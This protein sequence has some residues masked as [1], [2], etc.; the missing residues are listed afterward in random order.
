MA[1]FKCKMCGGDL[2]I[3]EGTSIA[4]CEYCGTRQTLPKTVDENLN[5]MFNRA[6]TLRIKSEFDK[7]EKLY[8]K[9][10]QVE[11]TQA[12]AY[13]GLILCR[14]GI[15]YVDDP[16][17]LKKIPTCHRASYDSIVADE[18]FKLALAHA[19]E[20]QRAVYEAEAREIDRIQKEI[21]ALAQKEETYDVFICYKETDANGERTHDSVIA[22]DIYYQ[23]KEQG[24]RVFY[25]AITLEGKLGSA[26]EPIIFAALHSAKVMLAI[27]TR[28]EYFNAVWVKNEWSRFL[29]IIK[30]DR[31]KLLIPCYR[32]MDA[33]ELPEEFA[34]LQAQ[35]MAKIGFINDIVRGIKRVM[36]ND[37]PKKQTVVKETVVTAT[38]PNI[39]P[40]L[41][42]AFMFLEDGDFEK[43]DEFCEQVLNQDPE[44]ARAYLGKLMAELG[45]KKE[46][47]LADCETPFDGNYNY[48]KALRFADQ[49]FESTLVGYIE[50][51]RT[52]IESARL[53][54]LYTEAYNAMENA[55]TEEEY[56]NAEGLF[57]SI[58]G[59]RD[60]DKLAEACREHAETARKDAILAKALVEIDKNTERSYFEAIKLLGSIPGWKSADEWMVTCQQNIEELKAKA[61]AYRL[62]NERLAELSRQRA[63]ERAKRLK[64]IAAIATPVICLI[65]VL[66]LLF[67]FVIIPN[68]KYNDAIALMDDG[69]Y[70]EAVSLFNELDGYK[71]SQEKSTVCMNAIRNT[72]EIE[73]QYN[74][75][76]SLMNAKRYE[77]AIAAF[78]V[79]KEYKDSATKINECRTALMDVK[80]NAAV[81]L[82]E[83][84]Q[85]EDAIVAFEALNGY[86]DSVDK[87]NEC[88]QMIRYREA[89]ELMNAKKYGEALAIF[90]DLGDFRESADKVI[91]CQNAIQDTKYDVAIRLLNAGAV[92][93]AYEA[94]I[95]LNG[96]KDSAE[97]AASI[98]PAYKI[99]KLK[100]A[101]VGTCVFFGSYEQDN[102][103]SNGQEELEW[104]VLDVQDGKALVISK[105]G[106]D[107]IPYHSSNEDITWEDCSLRGWLNNEFL[108]T[109]FSETDRVAI[110]TVTV[111]AS[112]NAQ[113]QTDPGNETQDQVFVLSV[114]EAKAYFYSDEARR[115]KPTK[116]AIARGTYVNGTNQDCSWWLRSPG[117]AQ[118]RIIDV[119]AGGGISDVGD[120]VDGVNSN[121]AVRPAM[122]I[123]LNSLQ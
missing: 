102:N 68:G 96:H 94:L 28:P 105:Y 65:V 44:N 49:S 109:A 111:S 97:K 67:H 55:M 83:S 71:D 48:Q 53:E 51:I 113:Y 62:E 117:K 89:F 88:G 23:L 42:R 112:V 17:T 92:I 114:E 27:G 52:R 86:K 19:D 39:A 47:E 84:S 87:I 32:D 72:Q 26:Y 15:E 11:P 21:L 5:N 4:E 75:A 30:K 108:N 79:V 107:C 122:W 100:N 7:A 9:I 99:E 2:E 13:W 50:A 10:I 95:A 81:V 115:C 85:Y 25:A 8:E 41:R 73:T 76:T 103:L 110:P 80:Y 120:Y 63:Q 1:L 14:Y 38:A 16:E 93:E 56:K 29:R 69:N 35:D 101:A 37:E 90:K 20:E 40:L 77:E 104:L 121:N 12:E 74:M 60:A 45:V 119:W 123:D 57:W 78:T 106:L 3:V 22:N 24:F 82:M 70:R 61:E 118:N 31:T 6:N 91:E 64:W 18:D 98:Y 54:A 43:A 58:G 116:Y 33:Y 46:E 36:R 66:A 59:Y 34:H